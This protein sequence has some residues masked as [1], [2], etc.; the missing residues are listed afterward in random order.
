MM[1]RALSE[2][3]N[4]THSAISSGSATRPIGVR[5]AYSR[6]LGRAL[7][8]AQHVLEHLGAGDGRG[9]GVD[10]DPTR[11]PFDP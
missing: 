5:P 4:A 9:D 8:R 6:A 10:P 3:R 11:G 7:Q 2:A 1:K